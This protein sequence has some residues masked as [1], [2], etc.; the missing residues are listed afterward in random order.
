MEYMGL[1]RV[2]DWTLFLN[3][4]LTKQWVV[5]LEAGF[6]F[7]IPSHSLIDSSSKTSLIIYLLPGTVLAVRLG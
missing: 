4:E 6:P 7:I 5:S 2:G 1:C 3:E